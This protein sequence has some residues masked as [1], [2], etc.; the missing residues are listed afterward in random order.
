MSANQTAPNA[1]PVEHARRFGPWPWYLTA[2]HFVGLDVDLVE[3]IAGDLFEECTARTAQ[4][5]GVLARLWCLTELARSVP[6][7]ALSTLRRGHPRAR[8]RLV[9][10]MCA[11]L[12]AATA[13]VAAMHM[14]DGPPVRILADRADDGNGIVINN[15]KP[16]RL[17]IHVLDARGH[18]LEALGVHYE[19][20]GG[21][22]IDIS[23]TGVL[24]CHARGDATVRASLADVVSV[25]TVR[26]RP[27][28]GIRHT[29]WID[30]LPGDP[31]K[32]LAFEAVDAAG[33]V[34]T[35]LR[36]SIRIADTAVASLNQSTLTPRGVGTS[37][38][39]IGIGDKRV[40][41]AVIVHELVK[42]FDN[43]RSDQRN[44]AIVMSVA[45]GDTVEY[46]IPTGTMWVK[47]LPRGATT[48]PPTIT[49]QGPGFCQDGQASLTLWLPVDEYGKYCY[50][51]AGTRIR[52]A[53]GKS[54]PAT[55]T[56]ALM[57][58]RMWR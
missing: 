26:C 38:V 25:V 39:T 33:Q 9:A 20:V 19:W 10:T 6:Y 44:V 41:A 37:S 22:H 2:A 27:V 31:P 54:G 42:R 34:V 12:L 46:P 7:L 57:I 16:V 30:F 23:P 24:T 3:E 8:L 45:R 49:M 28:V 18:T 36:G 40:R 21:D 43:L 35:Q 56:G 47:W 48:T 4:R 14:R 32:M 1:L 11:M 58:E 17:P 50:V 5:G 53:H 52:V 13:V 15:V 51:G 55:L 29:S